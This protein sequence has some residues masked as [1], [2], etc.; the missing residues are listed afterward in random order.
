VQMHAPGQQVALAWERDGTGL[1][2]LTVPETL[3]HHHAGVAVK[4]R[5]SR[6][7]RPRIGRRLARSL[8]IPACID[9]VTRT[10][11]VCASHFLLM[12]RDY[13]RA[14]PAK[15][16]QSVRRVGGCAASA[17]PCYAD[18]ARVASRPLPLRQ[19]GHARGARHVAPSRR[20]AR[21]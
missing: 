15:E 6:A 17:R 19:A 2:A 21:R 4:N 7:T 13:L 10:R 20:P 9:T 12:T 11:T 5:T 16:K 8:F 14:F 3:A 1:I 18:P